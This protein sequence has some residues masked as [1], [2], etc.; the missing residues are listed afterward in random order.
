[1]KIEKYCK[2]I[3]SQRNMNDLHMKARAPA[4]IVL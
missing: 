4:F 3:E 1:M 2:S